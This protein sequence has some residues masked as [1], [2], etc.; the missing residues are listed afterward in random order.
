VAIVCLSQT[1]CVQR[2]LT[3]RSNPPGA[4]VYIDNEEIGVTPCSTDYIYYGTRTIRLVKDGYETLT[5]LQPIP[6]PIYQYPG[7]DFV[8]ENLVPYEIRDERTLA[9]NLTPQVMV[10]TEEILQRGDELRGL[11]RRER[12]VPPPPL[13]PSNVPPPELLR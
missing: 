5:V 12:F 1:A 8:V 2:R 3:I 6:A 7:I 4:L 10:P 11:S 9:Y 13:V